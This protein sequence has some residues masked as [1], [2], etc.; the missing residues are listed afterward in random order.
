MMAEVCAVKKEVAKIDGTPPLV[1]VL[2]PYEM[3]EPTVAEVMIAAGAMR[4]CTVAVVIVAVVFIMAT[5]V[6]VAIVAAVMMA[7]GATRVWTV[8]VVIVAAVTI[9]FT[10][11]RVPRTVAVVST[12]PPEVL[13]AGAP[14]SYSEDSVDHLGDGSGRGA[15]GRGVVERYVLAREQVSKQS[16]PRCF[17]SLDYSGVRGVGGICPPFPTCMTAVLFTPEDML[18]K[19]VEE[20]EEP[21]PLLP[22]EQLEDVDAEAML[23]MP[24]DFVRRPGPSSG[25]G[26]AFLTRASYT[27][28]CSGISLLKGAIVSFRAPARDESVVN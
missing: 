8:A 7:V 26:S 10:E 3:I 4:V 6:A 19:G 11:C 5:I 27:G 17:G 24:E 28:K 22:P 20:G 12:R 13:V 14:R 21:P 1:V 9:A 18:E 15:H 16:R 2:P 23:F 25:S